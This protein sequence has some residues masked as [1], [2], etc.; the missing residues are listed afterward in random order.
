[1]FVR[2]EDGRAALRPI[3]G[4][5]R[6][7]ADAE[8]DAALAESLLADP[9]ERAEHC[10]AWLTLDVTTW[11]GLPI[12]AAVKVSEF[13]TIERYSHVMPHCFAC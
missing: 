10:H 2:L 5:R 4:T 6:R 11:S 13:S 8:A 7:G 12:T 3:A 9:K 1:M